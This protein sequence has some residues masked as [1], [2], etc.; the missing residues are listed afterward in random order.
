MSKSVNAGVANGLRGMR[1]GQRNPGTWINSASAPTR[2]EQFRQTVTG[3]Q[4]NRDRY[5]RAATHITAA[6]VGEMLIGLI[7][8]A[9]MLDQRVGDVDDG[10]RYLVRA[11]MRAGRH[12]VD[13]RLCGVGGFIDRAMQFGAL[14]LDQAS[15][16][17]TRRVFSTVA[18]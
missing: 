9:S 17:V 11:C 15:H 12:A 4:R 14:V 7:Q 10:G 3:R 1:L 16:T 6:G 13:R 18:V 5:N 2:A 8:L